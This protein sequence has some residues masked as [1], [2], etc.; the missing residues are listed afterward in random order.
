MQ[1]QTL[2]FPLINDC[3]RRTVMR[4]KATLVLAS[5]LA[6][7]AALTLSGKA[8]NG[9]VPGIV[10]Q[11]LLVTDLAL[12]SGIGWR[13]F[14]YVPQGVTDSIDVHLEVYADGEV[15]RL[16]GVYD[17][18]QSAKRD[19]H[20]VVILY[21]PSPD[22]SKLTFMVAVNG[23]LVR[24]VVDN[25]FAGLALCST[26]SATMDSQGRIMLAWTSPN[27][28]AARSGVTPETAH[29]CLVARI[30]STSK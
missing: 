27:G 26:Q 16:S 4:T 6:A 23:M 25:P 20:K 5:V 21:Q 19:R 8:D 28:E 12:F 24:Q 15:Q 22:Q 14:E 3:R 11:E 1:S 18:T 30:K 10:P 2:S 29:R 17:L 7:V 13:S 9:A